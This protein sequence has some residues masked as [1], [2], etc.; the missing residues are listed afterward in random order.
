MTFFDCS[1]KPNIMKV[2]RGH[3]GWVEF[4]ITLLAVKTKVT[5]IRQEAQ[6]FY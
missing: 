3:A 1:E 4:L 5:L 2:N 6:A